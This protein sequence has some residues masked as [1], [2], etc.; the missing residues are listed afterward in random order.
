MDLHVGLRKA[1]PEISC[2]A[3]NIRKSLARRGD[4]LCDAFDPL[5]V[6]V[7]RQVIEEARRVMLAE[8]R[9]PI[10]RQTEKWVR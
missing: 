3:A 5:H 6:L 2:G 4:Q 7:G 8:P 1:V 9:G 10:S